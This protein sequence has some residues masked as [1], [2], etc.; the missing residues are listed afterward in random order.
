M[1]RFEALSGPATTLP[2]PLDGHLR[3]TAGLFKI[4]QMTGEP[5]SR[6]LRTNYV[7]KAH[8]PDIDILC[9]QCVEIRVSYGE[10]D[11]AKIGLGRLVKT[12]QGEH[13]PIR[14]DARRIPRLPRRLE[15]PGSVR[16]ATP[17]SQGPQGHLVL[18]LGELA[19]PRSQWRGAH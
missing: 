15:R 18:R 6:R 7:G 5:I 14:R 19:E 17:L 13:G 8:R 11:V 16:P 12:R 1:V 10:N 2:E 4:D 9:R 3:I